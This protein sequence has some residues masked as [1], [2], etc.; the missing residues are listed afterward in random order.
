M[1]MNNKPYRLCKASLS[2]RLTLRLSC[3]Q[4]SQNN[5]ALDR[6]P[7]TVIALRFRSR[8]ALYLLLDLSV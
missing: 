7:S 3:S 4:L 8:I 2:H 1:T 5:V 6:E